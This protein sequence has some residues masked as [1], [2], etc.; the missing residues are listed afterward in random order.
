ME[1][2]IRPCYKGLKA[3]TVLA[4]MELEEFADLLLQQY[5][6]RSKYP[7]NEEELKSLLLVCNKTICA[8]RMEKAALERLSVSKA[9]NKPAFKKKTK[10]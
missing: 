4:Q 3:S 8:L 2:K 6:D 7:D 10:K 1:N 5:S 9:V